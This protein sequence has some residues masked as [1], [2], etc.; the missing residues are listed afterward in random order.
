MS[1]FQD[2]FTDALLN[3]DLA[4]PSGLVDPKG[5]VAGKRFDVYRNNV[6]HSLITAMGDAFPAI[7]KIVGDEFFDAMAGVYVRQHPPK[8]PMMMFYG[9]DF[10]SFLKGFEPAAHLPYLPEVARLELTRRDV[11]HAA[12]VD[13]LDAM[14]L[15]ALSPEALMQTTFEFVPAM[16]LFKSDHPAHSIW[17]FNMI[18]QFKI[19]NPSDWVLLTRPELDVMANVLDAATYQFLER[20]LIGGTL[21]AALDRGVSTDQNFDLSQALGLMMSAQIIHKLTS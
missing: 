18:E 12:D 13:P 3:P 2:S 20:L 14:E 6:V 17:H 7:K 16:R 21:E 15:T 1:E 4:T 19:T 11:Y 9:V 5:R 10:P 8:Q